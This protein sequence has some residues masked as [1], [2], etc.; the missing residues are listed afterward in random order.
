MATGRWSSSEAWR[1]FAYTSSWTLRSP[2][3]RF[4]RATFTPAAIAAFVFS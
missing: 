1:M 4:M 3:L 2:W